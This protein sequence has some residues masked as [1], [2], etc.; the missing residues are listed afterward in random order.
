[1]K[2]TR[3]AITVVSAALLLTGA[4]AS[5]QVQVPLPPKKI[6]QFAQPLP[7]L[8]ADRHPVHTGNSK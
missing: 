4:I 5:A 6:P 2:K 3:L 7:Q 8:G 1:M